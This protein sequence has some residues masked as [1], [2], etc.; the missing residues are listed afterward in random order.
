M[1]RIIR[2]MRKAPP[3]IYLADV[4]SVN[5]SR[6]GAGI[7]LIDNTAGTS[8]SSLSSSGVPFAATTACPRL[9]ATGLRSSPRSKRMTR[10]LRLGVLCSRAVSV[11]QCPAHAVWEP[12]T[13]G[14]RPTWP[15]PGPFR[16]SQLCTL[17]WPAL[18]SPAI[19][20]AL[21]ISAPT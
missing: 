17:C 3:E 1:F 12:W 9:A 16:R 10:P 2:S 21:S 11:G 8:Q 15:R 13:P 20:G 5:H 7:K 4:S 19:S 6:T 18:L 14:P